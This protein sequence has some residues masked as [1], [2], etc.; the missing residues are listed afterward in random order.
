[1]KMWRELPGVVWYHLKEGNINWAMTTWSM[2]MHYYSIKAIM[3]L[4][5]CK[6]E[7]LLF[8]FLLWPITGLGITAGAH[9]L[10]A[11]R[12]YEAHFVVRVLLMLLNSMANQS[13]LFHWCRD[14]RVHHKHSETNADPHNAT[15]GFFYSHIG[16]LWLKKEKDVV[17][18]GKEMDFSDLM[19]DPVIWFQHKC[20]PWFQQIM[21]FAV[22]AYF[23]KFG[24]GEDPYRAFLVAGCLRYMFVK[25]CTFLVNSAAHLYGD[26]PYDVLSYPAENPFVSF[27][28][29]GEGWHNWHHKYPYDYAT[30][31]FGVTSQFNPTKLFIDILAALG[32]VW[33]R[34]RATAAWSRGRARRDEMLAKGEALPKMGP[35][36]WEVKEP[37]KND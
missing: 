15:R 3:I 26:H 1:M 16:W 37:T 5:E 21:C 17:L 20:D 6:K 24:W 33:N 23:A 31:E 34:K 8:A 28:A 13:S 27:M 25:H 19:E 14:H 22:P 18:A 7:T 35:R 2:A 12:S 30:S 36:P 29:I 10:W 9:R 4:A 11:H 32:L